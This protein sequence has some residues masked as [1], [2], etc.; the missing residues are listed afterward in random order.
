MSGADDRLDLLAERLGHRFARPEL[1]REALTHASAGTA[2][3]R[4]YQRLEFLGDRVLGLVIADL[5]LRRHPE[6]NEGALARRHVALVRAE[7]L[8]EVAD[9][10]G[11]GAF[12]IL[13]SGEDGS[14]A[15]SNRGLLADA[16]EA[17]IGALY[18]DGGLPAAE[19]FIESQWS[20]LLA[21]S[22]PERDA[23]T[24]L[25]EWA[26]GRSLPLPDYTVLERMGPD[27]APV[28][29]V[30]VRVEGLPPARAEGPSKR[31]AEQ[32]AAAMLLEATRAHPEAHDG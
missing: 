6:E 8:A 2:A 20:Q 17:L 15:R 25:Q 14:G 21:A 1:L 31:I 16:C 32:S 11:L 28:F 23:K 19:C 5:L 3:A 7:T 18:L 30:E 29:T 27:H 22:V 4:D 10:I 12:L 24:A 13:S 26:Q 9:G